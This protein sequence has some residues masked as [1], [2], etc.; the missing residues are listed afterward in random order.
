[1]PGVGILPDCSPGARSL[2][3]LSVFER[4]LPSG[5][6]ATLERQRPSTIPYAMG[7]SGRPRF[8]EETLLMKLLIF[9]AGFRFLIFFS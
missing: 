8:I 3:I 2:P 5:N 4:K 1:M 9:K 7:G 6:D